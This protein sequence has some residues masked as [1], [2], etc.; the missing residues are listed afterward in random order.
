MGG[1]SRKTGTISK[2]L[3]ERIKS[4]STLKPVP[5]PEKKS[6]GSNNPFGF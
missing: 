2:K 3:I 6:N 1:K 4:G 5:K